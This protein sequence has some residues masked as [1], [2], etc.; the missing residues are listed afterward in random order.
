MP[1]FTYLN[2]LLWEDLM[3]NIYQERAEYLYKLKNILQTGE[4]SPDK[5]LEIKVTIN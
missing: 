3:S 5:V 4:N 2:W 1:D